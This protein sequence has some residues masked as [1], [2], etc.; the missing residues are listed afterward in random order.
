VVTLTQATELGTVYTPDELKAIWATCRS[1]DL[2]V[3]MDG[4]RFANAVA[5]LGVAPKEV[6]WQSGVDVLCF[7]GTK[8]GMAVG[9]AVIFFDRRLAHEFDYRLKQAGQLASKMR[10]LAAPWIGM[11][12][13]G[14][15]LS[16]ARHANAMAERLHALLTG[17]PDVLVRYPRQA[18]AVFAAMPEPVAQGLHAR[19]WH[20][21]GFI[22]SASRLMCSWDTTEDDVRAL[23]G[24]IRELSAHA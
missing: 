12:E 14:A 6:T 24:D 7:G 18:N 22:G 4:A 3:H 8:N 21:Y 15:W 16:H 17:I 13:G 11:L 5:S 9:E 10:F 2:R 1:L 20:F 19:G 23:V